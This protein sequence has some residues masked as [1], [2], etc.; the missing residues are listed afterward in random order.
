MIGGEKQEITTRY[1]V[2]G[3][4]IHNPAGNWTHHWVV[5]KD[6]RIY[7]GT[8]GPEGMDPEDFKKQW[9]YHEDIDFGF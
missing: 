8:T 3:P 4:S 1:P 7:D 5:K 2:M 9:E 6:G